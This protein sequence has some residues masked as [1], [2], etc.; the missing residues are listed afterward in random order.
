MCRMIRFNNVLQCSRQNKEPNEQAH[1]PI[2]LSGPSSC[3]Q[4]IMN[5]ELCTQQS[6]S[7]RSEWMTWH[8][9]ESSNE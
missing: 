9:N 3:H 2:R 4:V 5:E 7:Q 8:R 1:K 6:P